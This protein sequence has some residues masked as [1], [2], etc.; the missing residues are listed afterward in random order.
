MVRSSLALAVVVACGASHVEMRGAAYPPDAEPS[1]PNAAGATFPLPSIG[2]A[3]AATIAHGWPVW[4]VRHDDGS[5]SVLG[6]V[7]T[8]AWSKGDRSRFFQRDAGLVR[9]IPGVRRFIAANV[10]Y[11]ERGHALGYPDFDACFEECPKDAS[12]YP[13]DQR[14]LDSFESRVD[15]TGIHVGARHDGD[16]ATVATTWI[17][18]RRT[19]SAERQI[20]SDASQRSP[21]PAISIAEAASRPPGSYS[22]VIGS[23]VRATFDLPRVCTQ[24]HRCPSDAPPVTGVAGDRANVPSIEGQM[25]LFLLRRDASGGFAVIAR[26]A[27]GQCSAE[28]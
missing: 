5:V 4:I 12:I 27:T 13:R 22:I 19:E 26:I 7:T 17:P 3:V 8:T 20:D 11:D 6:A 24:C 28:R 18:W 16:V 1:S 14:D 21:V 23:I 9:W 10:V 2:E 25:G 15:D